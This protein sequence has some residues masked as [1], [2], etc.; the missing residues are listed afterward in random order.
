MRDRSISMKEMQ[1]ADCP[2]AMP[3][4]KLSHSISE[5]TLKT[6]STARAS[7]KQVNQTA[8]AI[9]KEAYEKYGKHGSMLKSGDKERVIVVSYEGLLELEGVY[10]FDLYHQLGISSTYIPAFI[11]DNAQYIKSDS[12]HWNDTSIGHKKG[13]Q[14]KKLLAAL[15]LPSNQNQN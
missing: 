9:K 15:D 11:D 7:V 2:M 12:A 4:K 6:A 13:N 14:R 10:L 3:T 1:R 8:L 5:R